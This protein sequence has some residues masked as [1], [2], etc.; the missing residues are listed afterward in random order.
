[1]SSQAH[2][3][4]TGQPQSLGRRRHVSKHVPA[5]PGPRQTVKVGE[6]KHRARSA[7]GHEQADRHR[8][9]RPL[10]PQQHVRDDGG[11]DI[12]ADLGSVNLMY[13]RSVS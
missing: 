4:V 2:Q 9:H 5:T 7:D 8:G 11:T 1:M 3:R 12:G 6:G 10:V 13:R